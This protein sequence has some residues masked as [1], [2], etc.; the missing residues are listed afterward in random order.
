MLIELKVKIML[1]I[2]MLY[3]SSLE[4][5]KQ[6]SDIIR[7]EQ[8]IL[9]GIRMASTTGRLICMLCLIILIRSDISYGNMYLNM[10]HI[11]NF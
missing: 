7:C 8:R 5:F 3:S 10:F 6:M 1:P 11:C 9:S 2:V 4:W